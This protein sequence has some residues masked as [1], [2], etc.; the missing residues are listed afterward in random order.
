MSE[1][2]AFLF[3]ISWNEPFGMVVAEAMAAGAPV[4]ATP[5]GSLPELVDPGVTGFLENTVEGLAG[6]V[7]R[8]AAIDRGA[9][10]RRARRLFDFRRMAQ[11]YE[12]VYGRLLA[13]SSVRELRLAAR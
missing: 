4:V 2:R 3:P 6:A 1:A 7:L 9:C 8:A 11:R 12:D 10:R 13:R 5:R